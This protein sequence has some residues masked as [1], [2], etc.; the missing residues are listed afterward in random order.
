AGGADPAG[1]TSPS[2]QHLDQHD[3]LQAWSIP[4]ESD[5]PSTRRRGIRLGD[6]AEFTAQ[7][8][9][10]IRSGVDAA[11]ALGSLSSQCQRP[12]L[13]AVLHSVHESVL[14]GSTLSDSL[15]RHAG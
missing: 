4:Q 8:A 1:T 6:V 3:D 11:T 13:A 2:G 5:A 9:I 7:L 12:A 15:R 14:S 10:M